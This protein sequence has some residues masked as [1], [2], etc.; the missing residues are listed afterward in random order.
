MVRD[1]SRVAASTAADE[2]CVVQL[3]YATLPSLL[4]RVAVHPW[5]VVLEPAT[6][7]ARRWEVWQVR[8]AGGTSWGHVHRDLMHP[9]RP[10]GGGP[11]VV[12]AE[13]R[14][15]QARA[16]WEALCRAPEYPLRERYRFWPGPNSNTFAAWVLEQA[17]VELPLDPRSVGR[18]YLR[19]WR[20]AVTSSRVCLNT[21]LAGVE[22]RAGGLEL[23]LLGLTLGFRRGPAA[24]LTPFGAVRLPSPTRDYAADREAALTAER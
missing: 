5:F 3:R 17:G 14:G 24:V 15:D 11:C 23:H 13:W 22:A 19:P 8:D 21:P 12:A 18:H 6:G 1:D 9:D 10:V 4:R 20:A 7:E 2:A 16:V